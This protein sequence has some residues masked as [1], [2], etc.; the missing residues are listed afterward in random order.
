MGLTINL[1]TA[2]WEV[3]F[4]ILW[5][6]EYRPVLVRWRTDEERGFIAKFA[7]FVLRYGA[8]RR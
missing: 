5:Q 4:S 1:N 6:L 2:R 8:D 7:C 3:Q